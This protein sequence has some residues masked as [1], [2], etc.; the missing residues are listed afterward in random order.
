MDANEF[1]HRWLGLLDSGG[2]RKSSCNFGVDVLARTEPDSAV[3]AY[4]CL[5]AEI[6]ALL[7]RSPEGP[8]DTPHTDPNLAAQILQSR[9]LLV[10]PHHAVVILGG[11]GSDSL[12]HEAF[13][14]IFPLPARD[15]RLV[16][17]RLGR[18]PV[19]IWSG[20]A[21]SRHTR[22]YAESVPVRKPS[23]KPYMWRC[24]GPSEL[25]VGR[26]NLMAVRQQ[27]GRMHTA[28]C[29]RPCRS[30]A[31]RSPL[32]PAPWPPVA[33]LRS[34]HS[35]QSWRHQNNVFQSALV[36]MWFNPGFCSE[37][38]MYLVRVFVDI[39]RE[40]AEVVTTYRSSKI[41]KYWRNEP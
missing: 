22:K 40:P 39:D 23:A 38:R 13:E 28:Q 8:L 7:S 17:L 32:T 18:R 26:E 16:I 24:V 33:G 41:A 36:E 27:R 21:T 20:V 1:L 2:V 12:N 5:D 25:G 11:S 35:S 29:L 6:R 4:P 15:R 19:F 3:D 31:G 34:L 9:A 10:V 37:T 14:Q 30:V